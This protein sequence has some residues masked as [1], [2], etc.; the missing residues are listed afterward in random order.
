MREAII[1]A[2]GA[3]TRLQSVVSDVPKPMAMVNGRPFLT[4]LFSFLKQENFNRVVLSAGY[5]HETITGF[6]KDHYLDLEVEYA[7][8]TEPLGTGGAL[9]FAA[10][11][12][13]SDTPFVFNG[14]S[15]FK[16]SAAELER[17]HHTRFSDF[18]I[19]LREVENASRYGEVQINSD[20]AITA[21]REKQE[22][23]APGLINGGVYIVNRKK[24]IDS[25][26]E[27]NFSLERDFLAKRP[28]TWRFYAKKFQAYF[29]DIGIPE[30]FAKAQ[31]ELR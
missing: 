29:I 22:H 17:F 30:D 24:F 11:K 13:V 7:I 18:S 1:L 12:A 10:S 28:E 14:D 5:M 27:G 20:N 9:R 21:F 25:T 23:A 15:L 3:G 26:P 19:A 16:V 8:E 4:Y 6:F 2:G 31:H